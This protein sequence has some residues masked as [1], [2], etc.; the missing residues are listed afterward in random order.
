[1]GAV[2]TVEFDL[3][4]NETGR[5]RFNAKLR[6][7]IE[8]HISNDTPEINTLPDNMQALTD[9]LKIVHDDVFRFTGYSDFNACYSWEDI[10]SDGFEYAMTECEDGSKVRIYPDDGGYEIEVHNGKPIFTYLDVSYYNDWTKDV[11]EG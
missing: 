4:F 3:R 5:D 1:M 11:M 8:E 9:D 6:Q 7:Y 10:M 2:Y